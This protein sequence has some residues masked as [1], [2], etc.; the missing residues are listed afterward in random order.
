MK[1]LKQQFDVLGNYYS[2][3]LVLQ[4]YIGLFY[5]LDVLGITVR[6]FLEG[7]Y[8]YRAFSVGYDFT[9][10][11]LLLLFV[12][13][14]LAFR[15]K[16]SYDQF[17][18]SV[19]VLAFPLIG[20][21]T[22]VI[23]ATVL[24]ICIGFFKIKW[25]KSVLDW[26]LVLGIIWEISALS[27]W[28]LAPITVFG[29]TQ[30]IAELEASI[31]YIST[32][33]GPYIYLVLVFGS[34]LKTLSFVSKKWTIDNSQITA[35]F[36]RKR[37]TVF[38][39]LSCLISVFLAIYP[40]LPA[41]NSD[42][43]LIGVD[44]LHYIEEYLP[45][46]SNPFNAFTA[47]ESTRPM[48]FLLIYVFQNI[49]HLTTLQAVTYVPTI[50]NPLLI[51][52]VYL[53]GQEVFEDNAVV[54]SSVIF[55]LF[56]FQII[57]GI[58]SFFLANMLG[59]ILMNLS[60]VFLFRST[61]NHNWNDLIISSIFG[62]LLVFTHPWT[63]TQHIFT[64][65]IFTLLCYFKIKSNKNGVNKNLFLYLTVLSVFELIKILYF[66]SGSSNPLPTYANN[67]TTMF[68]F[69][70][71]LVIGTRYLYAGALSNIPILLLSI[72]GLL[73]FKHDRISGKYIFTLIALSSILFLPGNDIIK[74]R[75]FYNLP[76]NY[77]SAYGLIVFSKN[78]SQKNQHKLFIITYALIATNALRILSNL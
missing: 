19:V 56:G 40:S 31:Y 60:L 67:F 64:V 6:V 46:E 51:I 18:P 34:L 48:I 76:F 63:F 58:Y 52:S 71:D 21:Q 22:A 72:I 78:V 57:V 2:L 37:T 38:L 3:L 73:Y 55:T 50:L 26:I 32:A 54:E 1:S 42:S 14:I 12:W 74:S 24:S 10:L 62:V 69:W 77:L 59:L 8:V 45:V 13:T 9:N 68:T 33:L 23:F 4:F 75:L 30:R 47:W 15:I 17:L 11:L 27:H 65:L 5:L 20:I 43:G 61:K 16:F 70:Q 36:S 25:N 49:F 29:Q 35:K 41:I 28:I 44:T 7:E 39:L 53:L 66:S